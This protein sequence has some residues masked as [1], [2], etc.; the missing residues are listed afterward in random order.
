M[1]TSANPSSTAACGRRSG[2]GKGRE[3]PWGPVPPAAAG[4]RSQL[5]NHHQSDRQ[6]IGGLR[7]GHNLRSTFAFLEL[8]YIILP[9][10]KSV[11]LSEYRQGITSME[12]HS[13]TPED[14]VLSKTAATPVPVDQIASIFGSD[15]T[16]ESVGVLSSVRAVLKLLQISSVSHWALASLASVTSGSLQLRTSPRP[17]RPSANPV[18]SH[19]LAHGT[20]GGRLVATTRTLSTGL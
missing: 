7:S 4:G 15:S 19:M 10:E 17:R 9:Q 8:F 1:E 2:R 3:G 20:M 18:S 14:I 16:G 13:I 5:I 11:H 6:T 12:I